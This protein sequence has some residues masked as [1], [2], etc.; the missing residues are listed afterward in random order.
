M[1]IVTHHAELWEPFWPRASF[2]IL[3]T[4]RN[5]NTQVAWH[6]DLAV[7]VIQALCFWATNPYWIF[8]TIGLIKSPFCVGNN[9]LVGADLCVGR[10]STHFDGTDA[11][12]APFGLLAG[13][14]SIQAI[15][16][17]KNP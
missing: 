8:L 7:E 1:Y 6:P 16:M 11:S 17:G 9:L 2:A 13:D 4:H 3:G 14:K 5:A 10:V 12:K 15:G